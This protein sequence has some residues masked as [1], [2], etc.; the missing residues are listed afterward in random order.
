MIILLIAVILAAVVFDLA[1]RVGS[2]IAWR[3][4]LDSSTVQERIDNYSERLQ[5][6]VT[7]KKISV[8]DTDKVLRWSEQGSFGVVIYQDSDLIYSPEWFEAFDSSS[9]SDSFKESDFYESWFSGDRGFE[10]YLTEEARKKYSAKLDSI[11]QGNEELYPLYCVDG[12]L[13][14]AF[15]DYSE[16]IARN[17]VTAVAFISAI[18][19]IAIVML[20][21]F[22][23]IANR[24][25][26]LAQNVKTIER[27][28][29]NAPIV[30]WGND[31][32]TSLAGNVD[33][34]RHAL[35]EN[36]TKERRAW[37]SNSALITAM[38]HD[39]RTPLTVLMGYLDLIEMSDI[40]G[41]SAEYLAI[42][43]EN[44]QRLK[45]LS[46]DL[47]SYF[48]VFGKQDMGLKK[49]RICVSGEIEGMIDEHVFLLREKGYNI[50]CP[51]QFPAAYS[52]LDAAYFA[53]VIDN[54]F[55]NI[56]KYANKEKDITLSIDRADGCIRLRFENYTRQDKNL[57]ESNRIGLKTCSK[58]M[59]Q[60]G[61]SIEIDECLDRFAVT[62]TLVE[63][64]AD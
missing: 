9:F 36:M 37:E 39:I 23:H 32:I 59:E 62:V 1:V 28:D 57:P 35:I 30:I 45:Q 55:S 19:V 29:L 49:T 5:K 8:S 18:A 47:F 24:V 3:Y 15:V 21:H 10:Q 6:Y 44:A 58:I 38:S 13:L 22:S 64:T 63:T 33:S 53:R 46:D 60:M 25:N 27:G 34:M 56:E 48:L 31:D 61:G 54:V 50:I 40:D 2:F 4:Y 14:V 41:A 26:K 11:L 17:T 16:E 12:T 52:D 51:E 42:C 43:R 20:V 7:D